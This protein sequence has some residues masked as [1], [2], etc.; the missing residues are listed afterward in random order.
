MDR[1]YFTIGEAN[2]MIPDLEQSFGRML[3]LHAQIRG[4]HQRLADSGFAPADEDFELAPVGAPSGVK[5]DLAT[6]RTL[7]DGLRQD[8]LDLSQRGCVVKSIDTGLVDWYA[9][10]DGRDV[11]LCWR[12]GEKEVGFWHEIDAGFNGR[13]PISELD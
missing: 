2:Q 4:A 11:F 10:L 6:L 1:R 12:L 13:R 3:Q 8:V 7:I 9:K 5:S